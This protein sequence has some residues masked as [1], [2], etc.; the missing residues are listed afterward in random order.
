MD[1]KKIKLFGTVYN[2]RD[3]SAAPVESPEF[4]GTPTA[5]TPNSSSNNTQIA[6]TA[7]VQSKLSDILPAVTAADN[8]KVLMV[9]NGVWVASSLMEDSGSTA[10]VGSATVGNATV[11]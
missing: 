2:L 1:L 3:D 11:G 9:I 8:G 7:F 4:T 5:P 10:I 6:T